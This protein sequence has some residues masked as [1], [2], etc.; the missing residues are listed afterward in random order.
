MSWNCEWCAAYGKYPLSKATRPDD[1]E[2]VITAQGEKICQARVTLRG[3][4]IMRNRKSKQESKMQ[5]LELGREAKDKITGVKG[6]LT[7]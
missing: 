4:R 1:E 2:P 3:V 6:M 7:V 5:R